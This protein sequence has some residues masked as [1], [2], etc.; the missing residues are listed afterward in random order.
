MSTCSDQFE[1]V[2]KPEFEAVHAK[3]DGLDESLRGNG[4]PGIQLRLDRL[5]SSERSRSRVLWLIAGSGVTLALSALWRT[6]L[7]G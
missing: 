3:L 1:Q 4:K 6:V 2:C 7:G 5:E